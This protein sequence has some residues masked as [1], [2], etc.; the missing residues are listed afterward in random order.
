MD[1]E[2]KESDFCTK[3]DGIKYVFK[4][5]SIIYGSKITNHWGDMNVIAVMNVW[6][7]MIGNYLTYRPILDFALNNLDPKGFVTTPMAFKELCSQA[8][9]IPDK[10][11][12]MIE[13]QLTTDEKLELAKQKAI[14]LKAIKKFTQGFGR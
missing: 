8:G 3:D 1:R 9:R 6:K 5:F 10:P 2:Y 4:M 12:S 11:H 7:E 14:A 13:K